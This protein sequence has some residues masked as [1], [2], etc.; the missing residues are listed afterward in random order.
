MA[1]EITE[2][3][4][5]LKPALLVSVRHM[6]SGNDVVMPFASPS[7]YP[8]VMRWEL[9]DK[10]RKQLFSAECFYIDILKYLRIYKRASEQEICSREVGLIFLFVPNI[11]M[12]AYLCIRYPDLRACGVYTECYSP[13]KLFGNLVFY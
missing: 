8:S 4:D 10:K 12:W 7:S 2:A 3:F 6:C 11:L 1:Q 13:S 9:I 5:N